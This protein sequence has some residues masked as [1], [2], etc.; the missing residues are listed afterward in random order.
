LS[1]EHFAAETYARRRCLGLPLC[2][3]SYGGQWALVWHEIWPAGIKMLK[4][5]HTQLRELHKKS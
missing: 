1:S 5:N 2:W 4:L 3:T